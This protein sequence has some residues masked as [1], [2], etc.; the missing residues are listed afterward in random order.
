MW[1]ILVFSIV[2]HCMNIPEV[3]HSS[4]AGNLV[5]FCFCLFVF[6]PR[7]IGMGDF[8]YRTWEWTCAPLQRKRGVLTTGL[9]GGVLVSSFELTWIVLLWIFFFFFFL[10]VLDI[11]VGWMFVCISVAY[12]CR[13]GLA[14]NMHIINFSIYC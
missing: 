11:S 12:I 7:C 9:P 3:I 10:I 6:W 4:V 8:N 1:G 13:G 14:G 5:S 2:L